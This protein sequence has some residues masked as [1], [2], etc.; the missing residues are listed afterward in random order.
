MKPWQWILVSMIAALIVGAVINSTCV[1]ETE[2][3]LVFN[4]VG[5]TLIGIF[6][7]IGTLFMNL[8]KMVIVPLVFSSIVV[9]IAGL[10]K[11][12]GF[13][14][15]GGKTLLYYSLSSLVAILV[16]LTMVN[17]FKPGLENG[18]PNEAIRKQFEANEEQYAGMVEGKLAGQDGGMNAVT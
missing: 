9:G 17:T 2:P 11:T 3:T 1:L 8:L 7:Y 12:D 4:E 6:D 13:A 10:G 15:L 16:G 14:R 18:Q 5:N